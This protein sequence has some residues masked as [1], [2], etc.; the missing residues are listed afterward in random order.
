V[1]ARAES[2]A[3]NH[4][5]EKAISSGEARES[6]CSP[7]LSEELFTRLV[8]DQAASDH[9]EAS[10]ARALGLLTVFNSLWEFYLLTPSGNVLVNR[11]EGVPLPATPAERELAYVQ[12][13]RRF[14]ELRHLMPQRPPTAGTCPQCGGSGMITFADQ[15]S[16][17]CGPPCNARGWIDAR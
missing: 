5:R 7:V 10:Y 1:S 8:E 2:N 3:C 16:L 17:F 13:A 6:Y 11:D 9:P 14:P 4:L 15:R 12:A